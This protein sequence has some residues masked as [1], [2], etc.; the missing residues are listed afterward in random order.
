MKSFLTLV[1]RTFANVEARLYR[2]E[3]SNF[4]LADG[5]EQSVYVP[6][7]PLL[8][9]HLQ[10]ALTARSLL[11]QGRKLDVRAPGEIASFGATKTDRLTHAD[12]QAPRT[13]REL[14]LTDP[15]SRRLCL[16]LRPISRR[17]S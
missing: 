15:H 1:F 12:R 10:S 11:F 14:Q 9:L 4:L 7:T 2:T 8:Q 13:R 5:T 16:F 3:C 17:M 6:L